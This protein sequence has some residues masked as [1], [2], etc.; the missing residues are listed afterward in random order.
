MTQLYIVILHECSYL[1]VYICTLSEHIHIHI[2]F[3]SY[4]KKFS[5][6]VCSYAV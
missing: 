5:Y 1:Y 6:N 4:F 2:N 3:V